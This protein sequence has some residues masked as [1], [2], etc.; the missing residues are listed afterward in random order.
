MVGALSA[1]CPGGGNATS[2]PTTA[3]TLPSGDAGLQPTVVFLPSDRAPARANVAIARTEE[4]RRRGLMYVQNLPP[5]SGMIFIFETD[6]PHA[7]WMHNTLISL[8]MI[9]VAK[10]LTVVGVVPRA[11]PLNDDTVGVGAPSRYVIEM[12]AGWAAAHGIDTGTQ[13]RFENMP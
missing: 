8:D 3:P 6:A 10:D 7:F 2:A 1:A 4:Q 12:N 5:D 11:K 9:F 13:V